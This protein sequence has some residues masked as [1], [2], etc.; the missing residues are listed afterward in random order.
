MIVFNG[1]SFVDNSHLEL[2]SDNWRELYWPAILAPTH[3]NLAQSGASN[4]RIWRTTLDYIYSNHP[5]TTLYVGWSG[6][7][8]MEL[9]SSNGDTINL[10][11][12][13]CYYNSEPD[14][15]TGTVHNHWY[16]YHHNDW[17]ALDQLVDYILTIQDVCKGRG[18]EYWMWN[19]WTH[20]QLHNPLAIWNKSFFV[21]TDRW[22]RKQRAD[23]DRLLNKVSNINFKRWLWPPANTLAE[24]AKLNDLPFEELGH[25]SLNAQQSIANYILQRTK[26]LL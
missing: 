9:P 15:D 2:E 22:D 7:D 1:C 17:L 26:T 23:R 6:I 21:Q 10:R 20:N 16:K 8:R 13:E 3:V 19:S 14:R 12:K 25:P 24:W 11:P 5:C 4:Q 18:I